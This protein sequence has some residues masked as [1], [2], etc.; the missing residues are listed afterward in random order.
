MWAAAEVEFPLG[1][2]S[3]LPGGVR[4]CGRD[5]HSLPRLG[6][7]LLPEARR[8]SEFEVHVAD[9]GSNKRYRLVSWR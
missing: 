2:G 9:L 7:A 3:E 4:V 6:I 8:D 5:G 1:V